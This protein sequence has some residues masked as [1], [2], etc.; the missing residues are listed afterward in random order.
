MSQTITNLCFF[1]ILYT[2][3]FF[4]GA[5]FHRL[6][7][8]DVSST[9]L[10]LCSW[11]HM[12]GKL[13]W[14][15]MA[16]DR[17]ING[18]HPCTGGRTSSSVV[19]QTK[20]NIAARRTL[21]ANARDVDIMLQFFCTSVCVILF[22][23]GQQADRERVVSVVWFD[24][25]RSAASYFTEF[26][27]IFFVHNWEAPDVFGGE[28]SGEAILCWV[29][30]K[31]WVRNDVKSWSQFTLWFNIANIYAIFALEKAIVHFEIHSERWLDLNIRSWHTQCS[32][33]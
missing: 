27:D 19:T 29:G 26:G 1:C 33:W 5:R 23:L 2:S 4:H 16:E 13:S 9:V 21:E 17:E 15:I 20:A 14:Q 30:Q 25:L 6:H 7:W 32:F 10:W 28:K 31:D 12:Y 3:I 22:M 24:I 18:S 11:V 8:S